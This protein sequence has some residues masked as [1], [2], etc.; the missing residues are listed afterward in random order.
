MSEKDS[1]K[2]ANEFIQKGIEAFSAKR[3]D[4]ARDFFESS[5][6]LVPDNHIALKNL[7]SLSAKQKRFAEAEE[8]LVRISSAKHSRDSY[9]DLARVLLAQGKSF[10]AKEACKQ[11]LTK[12]PTNEKVIKFMAHVETALG[13]HQAATAIYG[14]IA[15][16]APENKA[17]ALDYVKRIQADDP[18]EACNRLQA[19]CDL[20]TDPLEKLEV[21]QEI[22]L[23]KEMAGRKSNGLPLYHAVSYENSN[24]HFAHDEL[25]HVER[26]ARQVLNSDSGNPA[27]LL[28][29]SCVLYAQGAPGHGQDLFDQVTEKVTGHIG[30]AVNFDSNFLNSLKVESADELLAG[31][32][33][34]MTIQLKTNAG[35][36]VIVIVCDYRYYYHFARPLIISIDRRV[37]GVCVHLHIMDA[38]AQ[39]LDDAMAWLQSLASVRCNLSAENTD[40]QNRS[41]NDA[42]DY[43][44]AMRFVRLYEWRK[45][46]DGPLWIMDADA[47]INLDPS[48]LLSNCKGW[49][50]AIRIRPGRLEPWNVMSAGLVGFA[51]TDAAAQFLHIAAS[52]ITHHYRN[53]KLA[54]GI[55]QLALLAAH[56]AIDNYRLRSLSNLEQDVELHANG[57]F[58]FLSGKN[59]TL[60]PD[61]GKNKEAV[62]ARLTERDRKF[63]QLYLTCLS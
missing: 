21:L 48:K 1:I 49:D 45:T 58:W 27:A 12:D 17:L 55:D 42:L 4:E 57:L 3:L 51:P 47:L 23:L 32:P 54:W 40:Q 8:Y 13:D 44:H 34:V 59:K 2:A 20:L 36:P 43:Y 33:E 10:G 28:S 22:V 31:L 6:A 16:A 19:L 24:I 56:F 15:A 14:K 52:Y 29:L 53:G 9:F 30:A 63:A 26:L 5:L 25:K 46:Y 38:S 60:F 11:A 62:F 7:A 39:Q 37:R 50:V 18:Q 61:L 41:Q 35:K